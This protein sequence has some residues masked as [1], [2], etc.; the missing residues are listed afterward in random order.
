MASGAFAGPALEALWEPVLRLAREVAPSVRPAL[1][2]R[3]LYLDN[4]VDDSLKA[5]LDFDMA[6]AW[7]PVA[8][9]A[10]LR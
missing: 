7:D 8:D 4:F 3:D 10:K 5:I 2:H 1:S 6:E 9:F